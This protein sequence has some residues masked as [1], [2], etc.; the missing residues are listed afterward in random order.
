MSYFRA[1]AGMGCTRAAMIGK[2]EAGRGLTEINPRNIATYI[3]ERKSPETP[4]LAGRSAAGLAKLIFVLLSMSNNHLRAVQPAG[5]LM[6]LEL[7][8]RRAP[9]QPNISRG[10]IVT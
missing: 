4:A 3:K 7:Q 5:I 10:S 9:E 8:T 6:D 1:Y 2:A